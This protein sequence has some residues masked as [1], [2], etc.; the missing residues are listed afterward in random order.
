[1]YSKKVFHQLFFPSLKR[2]LIIVS[3]CWLFFF[4]LLQNEEQKQAIEKG[5]TSQQAVFA[6]SSLEGV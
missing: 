2:R 6:F 5:K 4:L 3:P 1:M